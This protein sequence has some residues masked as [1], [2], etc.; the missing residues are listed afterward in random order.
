MTSKKYMNKL[1]KY[2]I[3]NWK[4]ISNISINSMPY[5]ECDLNGNMYCIY[6]KDDV[7]IE[8]TNPYFKYNRNLNIKRKVR[9]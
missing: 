5:Y 2:L 8:F 4:N 3:K 6:S 7:H 9:K 1:I